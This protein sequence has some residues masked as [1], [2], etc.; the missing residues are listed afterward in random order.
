MS[1]PPAIEDY[2]KESIDH[3]LGL[4]VSAQT[5]SLKLRISEEAQCILQDQCLHLEAK[6]KEKDGLLE[7]AR[8]KLYFRSIQ[9][10]I[11]SVWL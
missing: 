8:V 4:P 5:L 10:P 1:L 7:L 3:S 9:P 11:F 6:L 2:I